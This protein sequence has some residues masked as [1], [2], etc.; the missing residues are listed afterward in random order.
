MRDLLAG[1]NCLVSVATNG[2]AGDGFSSDPAVSADG[3]YVAFSS[4]ANDLVDG[5][6]NQTLDVFVRDLWSGTTTRISTNPP[7]Y[8]A[9]NSISSSPVISSDA[10]YVLF[11]G[12]GPGQAGSWGHLF[13]RDLQASVTY[14]LPYRALG[15][16]PDGPAPFAIG[17]PDLR[18]VACGSEWAGF[19]LWDSAAAAV[20]YSNTVANVSWA[21]MRP[22]G[23]RLVY[24]DSSNLCAVDWMSGTNW[25]LSTNCY[26]DHPMR[27]S[28]DGRYLAYV[29]PGSALLTNQ[30]YLYDFNTG[31]R[32]LVSQGASGPGNASSDSPSISGDDRYVV[33]RSLATNLAPGASDGFHNVYLYDIRS[34]ATALASPGGSENW[35]SA[36]VFSANGQILVFQSLASDLATT[37]FGSWGGI[38]AYNLTSNSAPWFYVQIYPGAS[39]GG[40]PT[41]SWPLV[42]GT[43]TLVSLST[44]GGAADGV[45]T[46]PAMSADGRFVA[47][48]SSADDGNTL[49]GYEWVAGDVSGGM[50]PGSP[51]FASDMT[52]P[53]NLTDP[54]LDLIGSYLGQNPAPFR[55]PADPRYGLYHGPNSS[56]IGTIIRAVRSVSMNQGVGT[57]DLT[58]SASGAGHSGKPTL[59][60]N[61]P[62][63]TGNHG[64][65]R[66]GA[67]PYA[68]FGRMTDFGFASPGAIFVLVDENPWSINDASLAVI[69]GQS[70]LIDYPAS[71]HKN[72]A[73]FS[74]AD[75]HV[76]SHQWLSTVMALGGDATLTSA[77]PG[78][79]AYQDWYWLASHAT[80]NLHTG[81]VP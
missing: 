7:G 26:A 35:G 3:R 6:T 38:F 78:T 66:A 72:G 36:P 49:P 76:E 31:T 39:P 58:F 48:T 40:P 50:P 61:G 34:G 62:W 16:L 75:G 69:A 1:T 63:L 19:C 46:E 81:N 9:W 68:T 10:R 28:G 29:D 57:I 37:G 25:V 43:T 32:L 70:E 30:V 44:N 17:T 65:N 67:G 73:S 20:V 8:G 4:M 12:N 42:P 14:Q 80:K 24:L 54:T 13:L 56:L 51:G 60:T 64:A 41:L 2:A 74:F 11:C 55:C 79:P 5:D 21:A 27:F 52:N 22:D 71:Y 23:S 77:P 47:F 18:Y 33:Y 15:L 45:S 53:N 59:P